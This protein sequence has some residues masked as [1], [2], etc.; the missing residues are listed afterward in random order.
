LFDADGTL[1]DF[2]R[3]GIAALEQAFGL[4]GVT[5]APR[6]QEGQTY[7]HCLGCYH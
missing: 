6:N 7:S 3:A 4:I 5:F 2:D 1:F